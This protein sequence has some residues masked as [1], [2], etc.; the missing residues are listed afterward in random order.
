MPQDFVNPVADELGGTPTTPTMPNTAK[1]ARAARAVANEPQEKMEPPEFVLSGKSLGLLADDNP[2][3][4]VV[5][6]LCFN[7]VSDTFIMALVLASFVVLFMQ[8]PANID[9]L[10]AADIASI[11][12]MDIVVLVIFTLEC[13][14]K[15]VALGFVK[16]DDTYLQSSWNQ[17]DLCVVA[18]SWTDIIVQTDMPFFR[19]VRGLRVLRPLRKLRLVEG[20]TS[21]VHFYPYVL[22]VCLFM[23]FFMC[24]FGTIGVQ[25][26]GGT[27]SYQCA[28]DSRVWYTPGDSD[29][30][31]MVNATLVRCPHTLGCKD[32]NGVAV[33]Y[34]NDVVCIHVVVHGGGMMNQGAV[35]Y[36]Y[37]DDRIY[38]TGIY[39]FD[40]IW[41]AFVTQFVVTTMD[42]WPAISHPMMR[43]GG[44]NDSLVWLFFFTIVM[45]LAIVTANLFVS[46]ICF[47]FGNVDHAEE[48]EEGRIHVRKVRALFDRIDE[49]GG[50][51]IDA[52]EVEDLARLIDVELTHEQ[53]MQ[54]TAEMDASGNG[55]AN[56]EEFVHW[57]DSSS[58]IAAK[59]RRAVIAEEALIASSFDR[60]DEDGSGS[61]DIVEIGQLASAMGTT[62]SEEELSETIANLYVN[63]SEVSFNAFSEWWLA[64]S[65]V[66]QKLM[67]SAKGE[68]E[69]LTRMFTKLDSNGSGEIDEVDF[70]Q[71]GSVA[72]G[73]AIDAAK[74]AE[75]LK[76]MRFESP[77]SGTTP[78]VDFDAFKLWWGSENPIALET[79]LA[80]QDD[81]SNVRRMFERMNAMSSKSDD[82]RIGVDELAVIC[83]QLDHP[84]TPAQLE[85][86]MDEIDVHEDGQVEFNEFYIWLNSGA[87]FATVIRNGIEVLLAK[88]AVK[89]FPYIPGIS[90]SLNAIVQTSAFDMAVMTVV[91]LNTFFMC[92][93]H[94]GSEQWLTDMVHLSE[95]IFTIMYMTEAIMKMV[96]LGVLPYFSVQLNCMDFVIVCTSIAGF[97]LPAMSTFA[98]FRV[99]RLV[100]K[101]LRVV[102]LATVF[103][104]NDGMVMLLKTVI[105][106]SGL[107]GALFTF[108]FAFMCLIS[109]AAGHTMGIC[110]S[111]KASPDLENGQEIG[112]DGFPRENF[113]H[114]SDAVLSNFQIMSGEDWA[115]MMYRYMNCSGQWAV[116]YFVF[117]VVVTNFF[118][119]NI[120]VAV[121]LE[122]FELSEEEKLI[123]QQSRFTESQGTKA[124]S[125]DFALQLA[126][127]LQDG[128]SA[129]KIAKVVEKG[130]AVDLDADDATAPDGEE[131]S[132]ETAED[133][134]PDKTMLCCSMQSEIRM[135]CINLTD[136]TAFD[137]F[138]MATIILCAF[139]IA[140]EGP[141]DATYLKGEDNLIMLLEVC[142]YIIY[143]IFLFEMIVKMVAHGFTGYR[144][145]YW[146]N[147]WNRLDF[148]II[149]TS[150]L[151]IVFTIAG[152]DGH[153][154]R[155]FRVLRVLRPLRMIQFNEGMR[156]VFDALLDC[157]PTVFAVVM[158]SFLFY[159]T[160][161]IL[162][163]SIFG[164]GFYRCDCG[165][166]WGKPVLNCT[167]DDFEVLDRTDC[168]AQGGL[169]ENP[170][171]N[172][173]NVI[174]AMRTLFICSTTEGW[175]D[176]MHSGMDVTGIL[177]TTDPELGF[178]TAPVQDASYGYACYFVAFIL[179]GTFFITNIFIGVLVNFFGEA[180]GSLLLTS[181]QQQWMQTQDLCR[182]V[183]SKVIDPPEGGLR[184]F[185][186]PIAMS[187]IFSN[188]MN[189]LIL[190][191]VGVLMS[192]SVPISYETETFFKN[193]NVALLCCFTMEMLVK[194]VA[195]GPLDYWNDNWNKLDSTT[196][197]TSW[198]G[199]YLEGIG[200]VQA[201]RAI[202]VLRLVMLLKQAKTLRS[203]IATLVKSMIPASNI[204]CLLALVYFC[205]AVVGMFLYGNCRKGDFITELDNFDDIFH[206]MRLL[207]QISTGQD[208]M[209]V[210]H[211][212]ELRGA[213][214]VFPFFLSF[215]ITSIWVFFNFFVAVVLENFERNFAATQ[216]ELSI[217]HVAEFKR[218]WHEL[219]DPPEHATIPALNLAKLVPRLPAPLSSIVDEG[220]L[221][222]NRVLFELKIDILNKPDST[223]DFHQ[224]LLAL[225]LVS[226]SYDGLT[227]EEQQI[228][229]AEIKA[230][231]SQY[232]GRVVV[233]CARIW[234]L[235]RKPPPP[236]LEKR[237]RASGVTD[238]ADLQ[239]KWRTALRGLRLL[240]LD[241][242][243][244]T[245]KLG[246]SATN[247]IQFM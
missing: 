55:T 226:H 191:N 173:D 8:L 120:F 170:P 231:V 235:M 127:Q 39:G 36:P 3:R 28:D 94:H 179:V 73:F 21:V 14:L 71:C 29:P 18:L 89:P 52:H 208:F 100:V 17:L 138:I 93:E 198:I 13:I 196:V 153:F 57:W 247:T 32:A 111:P 171:Y 7:L 2:A 217:W 114:F 132:D 241:S 87:D 140:L 245:N 88:E 239:R 210:M 4:V 237:L 38:E 163:V 177:D 104:R 26:F 155:I 126:D 78:G 129:R 230:K 108:I 125:K 151:E 50:G 22:N 234:F 42:E 175:I 143:V 56:F 201:L 74:S 10:S 6:K 90:E 243:V 167:D 20:L 41:A 194:L 86:T 197:I 65:P 43:S 115:P 96:G 79:R 19:L 207:F 133:S 178:F 246:K 68:G 66:A 223:V 72:F 240:L 122:N 186:Y 192:E 206:A 168:I 136:S 152:N 67:H 40:N 185:I 200:G 98:S 69:K 213:Q 128:P 95:I 46:V 184:G 156:V 209:N 76:E 31:A 160:F 148:V 9:S 110:H 84:Q 5:F 109:I 63:Q 176:I 53:V 144:L 141:P 145:S 119:L 218:L 102:R 232:A 180:N 188:F 12:V 146:N 97:F 203:L 77:R 195:L 123:K 23:V 83:E 190:I 187:P 202:R 214:A 44:M 49:D 244:R 172:F 121:I 103:A 1:A 238:E 212:L 113:Y 11:G 33:K 75:I 147:G 116:L 131:D 227:Y 25:L 15:I 134:S 157:M 183:K 117:V 70:E 222:L 142:N 149:V 224:T 30:H 34:P 118:L 189:F 139:T 219:T 107:L 91:I 85:S 225:C 166:E 221:W 62:L 54:A 199:E 99:V 47:A 159:I 61:L 204:F 174:D 35:A 64:G 130:L 161:A 112:T 105:G 154:F 169:W 81:E 158:L 101:M 150:T 58:P 80:Q 37:A 48:D 59:L 205:F 27:L 92:L 229:Q 124:L 82:G 215:V 60:I 228:K 220:P 106:S 16:G 181:S 24:I 164:G 236:E 182:S 216:M 135:K 211:E 45:L 242:V 165:G 233:L 162:G 137:V 51:T 193:A